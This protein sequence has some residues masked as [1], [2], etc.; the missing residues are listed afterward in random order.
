MLWKHSTNGSYRYT[1]VLL[2]V[3]STTS[4]CLPGFTAQRLFCKRC[5]WSYFHLRFLQPHTGVISRPVDTP[6]FPHP[7]QKFRASELGSWL[8]QSLENCSTR[9]SGPRLSFHPVCS[10]AGGTHLP[11]KKATWTPLYLQQLALHRQR[12]PG[13]KVFITLGF[14]SCLLLLPDKQLFPNMIKYSWVCSTIDP[15]V[16]TDGTSSPHFL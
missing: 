12:R 14:F 16:S 15:T 5:F 2:S 7:L 10:R 1:A 3:I 4:S 13:N 6:S 11:Q 8:P 9:V